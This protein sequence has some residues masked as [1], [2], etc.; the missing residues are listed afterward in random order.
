LTAE[1]P[2][3]LV[4]QNN[5]EETP[6]PGS[7]W[8]TVR[9]VV[10][11][12]GK[13]M[14][15]I[16]LMIA[17]G[18]FITIVAANGGGM[19]DKGEKARLKT[20]LAQYTPNY[21]QYTAK[22][23]DVMLAQLEEKEG[24]NLPYLPRHLLWT[25]K[26]L[27]LDWGTIADNTNFKPL[28]SVD[29]ADIANSRVILLQYLP[30]TILLIGAAF[31]LLFLIGIPLAQKLSQN[32]GQLLDRAI[33]LLTPL[34]SMP[35]WVIGLLLIM[36]FSS[37]LHLFPFGR[38]I[39]SRTPDTTWQYILTVAWHMC[40]PVLAILLTIAFSLIYSWRTYFLTYSDEDYVDLGKAK[41]LPVKSFRRNYILRPVL[42]AIITSFSL[43]LVGFWQMI[44]TLE[45]VFNWPGIGWLFVKALPN[46][47][48]ERI[49]PG[50]MPIIIGT[51]VIFAYLL[52]MTA[53]LLDL[54]Y[55]I[56][57]PRLRIG[58]NNASLQIASH[59]A[60]SPSFWRNPLADLHFELPRLKLPEDPLAALK[61][62]FSNQKV[63]WMLTWKS[64][65]AFAWELRKYPS[66]MIGFGMVA[67]LVLTSLYT[68]LAL[69][70]EQI[71]KN[72]FLSAMTSR[73]L[74]PKLALPEWVNFFRQEALPKTIILDSRAGQARKEV[75]IPKG[76]AKN[77]TLT[78]TFDYPYTEFPN[79]MVIYYYPR[80]EQK[81][82]F[83]SV[84]ITTPDGRVFEL[85]GITATTA[86]DYPPASGVK[87]AQ[88]VAKNIHWQKWFV[89]GGF[90]PTPNFYLLFADPNADTP[91]ALPG[92][93][94]LQIHGVT[95]EDN[96][97]LDA[98]VVLFGQVAGLAGTDYMRR[99]LLI[100][101]LWG[102]PIALFFGLFGALAITIASALV[103]AA[104]AW[105]GG[106]VDG[107][108]QWIIEA[109]MILPVLAVGILF[110]AYYH[111]NLWLILTVIVLLNIFGSPA[112]TFRAAFLQIKDAPYVE[113]ARAYG[114]S[115]WRIIWHYLIPRI[116]PVMLPQLIT[117]IPTFAFL[118]ATFAIF[119]VAEFQYP[120][121]GL[122]IQTALKNSSMFTS[123]SQF[124]VLEPIVM[125]L[126]T[127]VAFGLSGAAFDHILN[128]RLRIK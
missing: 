71:G 100:P 80:Y 124:W 48:N 64:T 22:E 79:D 88:S 13:R 24:L 85:R 112:K 91:R 116:T 36:A 67:I 103:G 106:W 89:I 63:Q 15:A 28:Y 101:L 60:R 26:A 20:V 76:G 86:T 78:Y 73:P 57:D 109:N 65:K 16:L 45:F 77:I 120:T 2:P 90:Y 5:W 49:Y 14:I 102:M 38:M 12:V 25:F 66:A 43:S 34:S 115:N 58:R 18:T 121:W 47:L 105:Y 41:G 99:D 110:Y 39:D 122:V 42:P 7:S 126:L 3:N 52:G 11:F 107:L 27:T 123:G 29:R 54:A 37:G 61:N 30:N 10:M 128:P 21:F 83:A 6:V 9:N 46:F 17:M 55:V 118:E 81:V 50:E 4:E 70:Y 125:L 33:S 32:P 72:W 111:V 127:G 75:G 51:M 94:Q 108:L 31:L 104:A 23:T 113:A 93:Y 19:L 68:V 59:Q 114:A 84:T 1:N 117:L 69:P 44:T 98:Q 96:S 62:T 97:D 74:S 8:D 119:N 95:F 87:P 82:P 56:V 40:L 35:S 53:L 92:T